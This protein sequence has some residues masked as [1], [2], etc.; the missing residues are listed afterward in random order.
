MESQRKTFQRFK[1]EVTVNKTKTLNGYPY[2][3]NLFLPLKKFLTPSKEIVI[4][5]GLLE[6]FMFF[7]FDHLLSTRE[8]NTR[9]HYKAYFYF[10]SIKSMQRCSD[11]DNSIPQVTQCILATVHSQCHFQPV[12]SNILV[13]F[14][15]I[16]KVVYLGLHQNF[17]QVEMSEIKYTS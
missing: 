12:F 5:V 2:S 17:V 14:F 15:L 11:R 10:L 6:S 4:T 9:S 7:A 13:Q 8:L 3:F 16:S 1:K